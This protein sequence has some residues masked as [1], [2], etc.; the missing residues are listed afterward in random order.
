VQPDVKLT[1]HG[2]IDAPFAVLCHVNHIPKLGNHLSHLR[3]RFQRLAFFQILSGVKILVSL[4]FEPAQ[5]GM[6]KGVAD[7]RRRQA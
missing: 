1:V 2:L 5:I 3:V 7:V 6:R 4:V